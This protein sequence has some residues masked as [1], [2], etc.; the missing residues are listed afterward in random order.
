VDAAEGA[1]Q[2]GQQGVHIEVAKSELRR[3][4]A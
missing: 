4:A 3:S 1:D 2:L